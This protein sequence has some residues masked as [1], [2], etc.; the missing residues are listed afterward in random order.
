MNH[1]LTTLGSRRSFAQ[2]EIQE[3]PPKCT[4][5]VDSNFRWNDLTYSN[6]NYV[7]E[8]SDQSGL[9]VSLSKI[10]SNTVDMPRKR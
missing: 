2:D 6:A 7:F 1:T 4:P 9:F 8:S 10:M 3:Q 5:F